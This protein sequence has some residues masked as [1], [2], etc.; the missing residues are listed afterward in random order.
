MNYKAEKIIRNNKTIKL[1]QL[2]LSY[3]SYDKV[4]SS[5]QKK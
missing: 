1:R 4:T 5:E 3:S 2:L